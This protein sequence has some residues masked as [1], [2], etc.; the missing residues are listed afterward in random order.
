MVL[1]IDHALVGRSIAECWNFPPCLVAMMG[2]HHN[3]TLESEHFD[4]AALVHAGNWLAWEIGYFA[5]RHAF[6]D[7]LDPA[8][9]DWLAF[10]EQTL[11]EVK[12]EVVEQ[13]KAC[14]DLFK[15]AIASR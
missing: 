1:G 6:Q 2:G 7:W 9:K 11:S 15:L 5:S 3:P 13:V 4:L 12:I 10:D 14:E 8:V